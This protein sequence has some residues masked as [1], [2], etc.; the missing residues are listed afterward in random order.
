MYERE[1]NLMERRKEII[2]EKLIED[3]QNLVTSFPVPSLRDF[4]ENHNRSDIVDFQC[5]RKAD[6]ITLAKIQDTI[7]KVFDEKAKAYQIDEKYIIENEINEF[8][9]TFLTVEENVKANDL[10]YKAIELKSNFY[11]EVQE[12]MKKYNSLF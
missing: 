3:L 12:E 4:C 9:G 8:T 1:G 5:R 11:S 7:D 10:L 6:Y 2:N